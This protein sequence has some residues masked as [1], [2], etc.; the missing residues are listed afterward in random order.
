MVLLQSPRLTACCLHTDHHKLEILARAP[1]P[2]R[3][4]DLIVDCCSHYYYGSL[5]SKSQVSNCNISISTQE[6]NLIQSVSQF[7]LSDLARNLVLK[8][9][10]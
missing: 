6:V 3:T 2:A 4:I 7:H 5:S 10:F 1:A 8:S 9:L